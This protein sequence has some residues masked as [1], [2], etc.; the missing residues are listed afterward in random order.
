MATFN[1]A[2]EIADHSVSTTSNAGLQA[3]TSVLK[4]LFLALNVR[5]QRQALLSLDERMLADIGLSQAD[6]YREAHRP[7]MDLPSNLGRTNSW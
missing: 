5:R 6:V 1:A 4:R 2:H 3:G 7:L